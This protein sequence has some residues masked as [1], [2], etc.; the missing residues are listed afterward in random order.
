MESVAALTSAARPRRVR[1]RA[2]SRLA[3]AF[4]PL[5][6][7]GTLA[8]VASASVSGACAMF[9]CYAIASAFTA[10]WVAAQRRKL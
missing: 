1:L 2:D 3:L 7:A 8:I 10:L 5:V 4:T 9:A 6:A